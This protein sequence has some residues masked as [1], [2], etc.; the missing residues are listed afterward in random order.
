MDGYGQT[1]FKR[2]YIEGFPDARFDCED[3]THVVMECT[4]EDNGGPTHWAAIRNNQEAIESHLEHEQLLKEIR[5]QE[6]E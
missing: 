3:A 5:T 2:K 1:K 4:C 6:G